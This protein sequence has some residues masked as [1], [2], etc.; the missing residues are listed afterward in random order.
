MGTLRAPSVDVLDAVFTRWPEIVGADVAAHSRPL[1]VDG[2]TLT[3]GVDDATW[4]SELHWLEAEVLSR[5]C[6]VTGSGRISALKVRVSRR[7]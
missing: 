4:G 7:E 2:G 3:V 5:I 1:S 6:D